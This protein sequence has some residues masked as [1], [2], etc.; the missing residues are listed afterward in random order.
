MQKNR[1]DYC[2]IQTWK[3]IEI[4]CL[5]LGKTISL[6]VFMRKQWTIF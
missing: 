5:D 3:S 6:G 4:W 2:E 1:F